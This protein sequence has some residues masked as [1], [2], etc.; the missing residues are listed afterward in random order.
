M[1]KTAVV[2]LALMLMGYVSFAQAAAEGAK[3]V[4]E[5]AGTV[6]GKIVS[7][8]LIDP[9]KGITSGAVTIADDMGKTTTYTVDSTAKIVGDTLDAITLNQLKI[10]EK[11]QINE[12]EA[13]KAES[14]KVIK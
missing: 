14:I 3:S 4:A 2:L 12:S 6:V 1:K 10:G 7:V 5:Q 11:I 9:A 13:S 8:T